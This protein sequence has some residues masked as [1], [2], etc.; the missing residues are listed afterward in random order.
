MKVG[1][2][3]SFCACDKIYQDSYF[4]LVPNCVRIS[5]V[6]V[7]YKTKYLTLN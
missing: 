5:T 3:N 2:I 1:R 4:E 7:Y 6:L